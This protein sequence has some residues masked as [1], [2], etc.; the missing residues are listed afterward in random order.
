[1]QGVGDQAAGAVD[2]RN[3][4]L[5]AGAFDTEDVQGGGRRCG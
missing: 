1:M 5:V 3:A 2:E 4:G